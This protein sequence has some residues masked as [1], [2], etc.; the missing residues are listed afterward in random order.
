VELTATGVV[1]V[2][3]TQLFNNKVN[4]IFATTT[5]GA[6]VVQAVNSSF[7]GSNSGGASTQGGVNAG[8]GGNITVGSS[9]FQDLAF[10]AQIQSGGNLAVD[11]SLFN[12][13]VGIQTA[14]GTTSNASNNSFYVGTVCAGTGVLKSPG[15]NKIGSL[16]SAGTC[17]VQS[18]S[19]E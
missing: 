9:N 3:H 6:A 14:G 19:Q 10:G 11:S 8:A 7:V 18:M 5:S 16:A 1:Q 15:N 17:T 13:A 2:L 4:A 12:T